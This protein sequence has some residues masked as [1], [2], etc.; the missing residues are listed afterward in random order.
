[1]SF[2]IK[3]L[4]RILAAGVAVLGL[5]VCVQAQNQIDLTFDNAANDGVVTSQAVADADPVGIF[6]TPE[7][8]TKSLI[9]QA[10]GALVLTAGSGTAAEFGLPDS[11]AFATNETFV[12]DNSD[13][14]G[15]GIAV[16]WVISDVTSETGNGV[17]LAVIPADVRTTIG[18]NMDLQGFPG[19]EVAGV[20]LRTRFTATGTPG[21]WS[22]GISRYG[23][24]SGDHAALFG[25]NVHEVSYWVGDG[26]NSGG[27]FA[28]PVVTT[29]PVT[30]QHV[31]TDTYWAVYV[32]GQMIGNMVDD[33]SDP[34]RFSAAGAEGYWDAGQ[35]LFGQF[36]P[37]L[38]QIDLYN[39]R[40]N[41]IAFFRN[42]LTNHPAALES[43]TYTG[44]FRVYVSNVGRI[45]VG[46]SVSFDRIYVTDL[47]GG[48]E[49]PV[50]LSEFEVQ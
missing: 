7:A 29:L 38:D 43:T 13:P 50:E 46:E 39:P 21:E 37:T 15:T 1:M 49:V 14:F 24:G 3:S 30:I 19:P 42:G 11:E 2:H 32:N 25:A 27:M 9:A 34:N 6:V 44:D 22:V 5:S 36:G 28:S 45:P 47:A 8:A 33:N 35:P 20:Q 41:G 40:M 16:T 4:G 26:G 12:L 10:S 17:N 18:E 23:K 31:L 48:L